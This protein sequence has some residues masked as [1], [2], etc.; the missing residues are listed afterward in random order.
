MYLRGTYCTTKQA[1]Y[2]HTNV[3]TFVRKIKWSCLKKKKNKHVLNSN[4]QTHSTK[5]ISADTALTMD[6]ETLQ[7]IC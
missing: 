2:A 1:K 6:N 3:K 4:L 7:D 5:E